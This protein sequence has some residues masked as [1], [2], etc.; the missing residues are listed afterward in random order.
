MSTL[1]LTLALAFVFIVIAIALLAMSWLITG[2]SKMRPGACGRDP[3]KKQEKDDSCGTDSS[4]GLCKKGE[5][6]KK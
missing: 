4:C 1:L 3:T 5:D 6:P 2:K